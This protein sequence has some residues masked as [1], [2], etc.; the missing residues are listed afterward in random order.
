M[1]SLSKPLLPYLALAAMSGVLF[2]WNLGKPSLWDIDEGNNAEAAREML[3][4][5]EWIVPTFNYRLRP[6]KPALL[7]W[8]QL[9]A[10]RL[11]GV[12]ELAARLP[13]ALAAALTLLV[14]YRL[15]QE[16]TGRNTSFSPLPPGEGSGV[17]GRDC[18]FLAATILGSSVSVAAAA[19]FANPDA[20]LLF[21][22]VLT[23]HYAWRC[24]EQPRATTFIAVGACMGAATLTKG[25]VGF[26]LPLLAVTCFLAT[27][28]RWK[29][30]KD[31]RWLL[32]GSA[33]LAVAAPW[34][35]WVGIATRLEFWR[36]FFLTHNAGRFWNAME[37]H[38]GTPF[39]YL[40]CLVIG[41]GPWSALLVCLLPERC[42]R[43]GE[44]LSWAEPKRYLWCWILVY[45]VFFSFSST[46]LPNYILPLYPPVA[47]LMAR[48]LQ[49]W[50]LGIERIPVGL[51]SMILAIV[52]IVGTGT[53][54]LA[55]WMGGWL[56]GPT[57]SPLIVTHIQ[58]GVASGAVLVAGAISGWFFLKR[59]NRFQAIASVAW[60]SV[61]F[62]AALG[63]WC[64]PAVESSKAP[65]ALMAAVH[66]DGGGSD[67]RI[68]SYRYFEPSFV[69]YAHREVLLQEVPEET[70]RYLN[71]PMPVYLLIREKDWESLK[72]RAG[73]EVSIV[74]R[75]HDLYK[76]C[77]I[78]VVRNQA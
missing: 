56:R 61:V 41:L 21:F 10:Y 27:G 11:V 76:N 53:G 7:Y 1:Q 66:R 50:R 33:A 13:S 67:Y 52:A 45:L 18:G 17:R 68:V 23:F 62:T 72:E 75:R 31:R 40:I 70:L 71:F 65:R 60:A 73:P 34:F 16:L 35:I 30:L 14:V 57:P 20:L 6:D 9:V 63:A 12:N 25:P 51:A 3:V 28:R 8:L 36:G 64:G 44:L 43:V 47:I 24:L 38:S 37:G 54:A 15:G 58:V 59:N 48:R 19:H 5:G 69:F 2:F 39:Y 4:S 29:E 26:L 74:A 49:R 46:K 42:H 78:L 55:L 32:A 77:E 22:T